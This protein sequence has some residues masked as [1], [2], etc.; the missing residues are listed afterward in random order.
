VHLYGQ[1]ADLESLETICRREGLFL[2][3]DCAQAQLAK[4]RG[5]TAGTVGAAGTFSFYPGKNL[6]A[7][8]D[9]G[10]IVTNDDSLAVRVRM[11]AN[12]GALVKHAHEIEGI[13]S[14]LDGLQAAILSAKLRHLVEWNERRREAAGWY[15]EELEGTPGVSLPSVRPGAEHV[16]H[17]YV[18]RTAD[19]D[20]LRAYLLEHGVETG[21]HYPTALPFLKAYSRLGH[22]PADFPVA[23]GHQDKI[24]SLPLFPEIDR[25]Q[26]RQIARLIRAWLTREGR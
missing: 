2:V 19:R 10:A 4:L 17:L 9:A 12:H 11:F 1:M 20:G 3:E 26:V 25:D 14:R 21:I 15:A 23:H 6:G 5:R 24:L 7:F 18:I 8:G 16:F 22:R 13:N